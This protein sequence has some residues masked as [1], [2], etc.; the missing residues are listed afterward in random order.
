MDGASLAASIVGIATA[1]IQVSIKVVALAGQVSTAANRVSAIGNDISLTSNIL[2]QLG[3][4]ITEKNSG[5]TGSI[6]NRGGLETTRSSAEIC[7][8]IFLEVEEEFAKASLLV[9]GRKHKV[10][11]QPLSFA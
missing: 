5:G 4:L 1:G 11:E 6:L 9:R 2:Q 8:R 3:E 7:K 10:G